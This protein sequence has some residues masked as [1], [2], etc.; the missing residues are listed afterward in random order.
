L[1]CSEN[2]ERKCR[3]TLSLSEIADIGNQ[4]KNNSD[5]LSEKSHANEICSIFYTSVCNIYPGKSATINLQNLVFF[6][7][8]QGTTG[9]PKGVQLSHYNLVNNGFFVG[10]RLGLDSKVFGF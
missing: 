1:N 3:G 2:V 5:S 8:I 10:K 9:S 7:F 6:N 4:L